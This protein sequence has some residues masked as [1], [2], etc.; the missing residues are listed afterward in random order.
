M[1]G[2]RITDDHNQ[3]TANKQ[4]I[5]SRARR[6]WRSIGQSLVLLAE[7]KGGDVVAFAIMGGVTDPDRYEQMKLVM[8][9][10]ERSYY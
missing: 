7:M 5:Q 10:V 2:G 6:D 1:W 9:Y 4:R 3:S 8:D